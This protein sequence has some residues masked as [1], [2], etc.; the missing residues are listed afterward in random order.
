MKFHWTK[1][2]DEVGTIYSHD[3]F[4]QER[5][6]TKIEHLEEK[7][8]T[9]KERYEAE[10]IRLYKAVLKDWTQEEIQEAKAKAYV[11][12]LSYEEKQ[13]LSEEVKIELRKQN[14]AI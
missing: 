7:I 13:N 3:G 4:F 6:K 14:F 8:K 1:Y 2:L 5:A 9:L 11:N 10:E 12:N